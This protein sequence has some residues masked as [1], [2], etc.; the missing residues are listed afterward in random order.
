MSFKDIAQIA[1]SAMSAQTVRL[2]TIASNL[3]NADSASGTEDAT[4][5]ARKPV[6]A[7][8]FQLDAQ[9]EP[10]GAAVQVL[11][12]VKST[13]PL[14]KV[15]Q[16]GHP[17][18]DA[19]GNVLYPNVNPVEEMT[20]MLSASRAYSTNVEVLGR[21]NGMQLELLKLGQ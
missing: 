9:G 15:H 11:D 20:D 3:A 13:E 10:R 2:N 21:V 17:L 5:R 12:V 7:S 16:P 14:R 8:I 18:A 4:Y 1:G 6:F 19:E